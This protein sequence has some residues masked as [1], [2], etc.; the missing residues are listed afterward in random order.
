M[1]RFFI[2]IIITIFITSCSIFRPSIR[3]NKT[4]VSD[5]LN[6]ASPSSI[7][8]EKLE[9][10]REHYVDAL[11]QKKLGFKAKA[12][13][14]FE[15]SLN[16]INELSY[17]PNIDDNEAYNE[18]QNAI[19]DDYQALINSMDQLP[20]SVSIASL[21]D[22]MNKNLESVNIQLDDLDSENVDGIPEKNDIINIGDFPLEVN[23]YVEKYIEYFTSRGRHQMEIWLSRSG[24][25]FPMMAKIFKKEDV[26]QQLIFLSMPES[27]LNPKAHSWAS[28]V[29]MWQ[30]IKG[31]GRLY[32]LNVNFYV[33][34]R[35]NPERATEAAAKH[36]RDLYYSL[37]DWYLAIAAYNCGEGRVRRA[38]RRAGSSDYWKLRR[39]LPRETRNY[40]PQYIAVTMIASNPEKYGFAGIQYDKEF[41]YK[42]YN[43][44]SPVDLSVL[45]KCAGISTDLLK[46]MNPDRKSVV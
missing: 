5:S 9:N 14:Q 25:Y 45:A 30:F 36:L 6:T 42:I 31:T 3:D 32:D 12:I 26:P 22:W 44:K 35:R 19:V 2:F 20:D 27:G 34:E 46:E 40:V 8:N 29:G 11:Y 1:K 18:L 43:L 4:Q 38:I 16:I 21:E 13:N 39:F 37:G 28:A 33:D 24:R 15:Q 10:A 17:Y 23:K 7:V 41:N